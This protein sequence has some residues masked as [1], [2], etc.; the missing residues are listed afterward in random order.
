MP[1]PGGQQPQVGKQAV[2]SASICGLDGANPSPHLMKKV[3][4]GFQ[5]E[6]HCLNQL[7]LFSLSF[8]PCLLLCHGWAIQVLAYHQLRQ[9]IWQVVS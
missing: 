2:T 4:T 7:Q 8:P 9:L 1:P 5:P 3:N 6:R